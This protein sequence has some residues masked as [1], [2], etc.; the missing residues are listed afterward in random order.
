[1]QK[2]AILGVGTTRFFA[3]NPN[4]TYYELAYES[5][6]SALDFANLELKDIQSAVFGIYNDFFERQIMPDIYVA[7]H[8]GLNPVPESR[9]TCGGATG[10]FAVRQGFFEV[11][12][13]YYDCVLV[14]GVEKCTDLIDPVSGKTT[15]EVLKAIAYSSDMTFEYPIG[16]IAASSYALNVNRHIYEYGT[17]TPEQMAKVSVKNHG[18]AMNNPNA[19]SPKKLTIEDVLNSP[20]ICTPFHFY[21]CCLYSEGSASLILASEKFAKRITESPVYITGIGAGSETE[22]P[23]DRIAFGRG[24]AHS[25]SLRTAAKEAYKRANITE[26]KKDIQMAELHDAFSGIEPIIYEDLFFCEKGEGG[27]MVDDGIVTMNGSLPVSPSGGLIGCGHPVGAT[28]VYQVGECA[29]QIMGKAGQRQVKNVERALAHSM[30]GPGASY[31]T[32]IIVER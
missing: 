13:G 27:K 31:N 30:G 1:M 20:M 3:S 19:Q 17:P 8:I 25:E 32:V 6:K 26:P 14:C 29:L 11:A 24:L 4:K 18:N 22:R 2:V 10:G 28:G 23:G 9:I 12:S 15:P 16:L 7:A 21:D 5:V